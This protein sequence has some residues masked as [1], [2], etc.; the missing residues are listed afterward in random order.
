MRADQ[1]RG[2]THGD[3]VQNTEE[4]VDAV[5]SQNLF[6][7]HLSAVLRLGSR[8]EPPM[9]GPGQPGKLPPTTGRAGQRLH[10]V[11]VQNESRKTKGTKRNRE[12]QP[13]LQ[14]C[15][16]SAPGGSA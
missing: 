14:P 4:A 16:L 1:G 10:L 11:D 12:A 9:V 6:D 15:V 8:G 13:G 2:D 5:S 3:D 7:R